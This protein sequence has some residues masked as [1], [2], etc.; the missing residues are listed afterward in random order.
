MPVDVGNLDPQAVGKSNFEGGDT[1]RW[2]IELDAPDQITLSVAP[3][4]NL[5]VRFSIVGEDGST[6]VS[7][8]DGGVGQVE[9]LSVYPLTDAGTYFVDVE[10]VNGAVGNYAILFLLSTSFE[11]VMQ[12]SLS[13]GDTATSN[14]PADVDHFWNFDGE[15]G[16]VIT[17]VVS[18]D[19]AAN[20]FVELFSPEMEVI[21]RRISQSGAGE[22]R[23]IVNFTLPDTGFYTIRIG[24]FDFGPAVYTV[25][26]TGPP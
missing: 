15:D 18:P 20:I 2:E 23:E 1:H 24:E 14:L 5:D 12:P 22:V 7:I 17:I 25:S 6:L 19:A 26:L 21:A 16:D 8:N 3:A 13:Y 4:V 9:K 10:E 11:F